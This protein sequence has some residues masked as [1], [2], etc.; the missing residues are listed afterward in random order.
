MVSSILITG[1]GSG[2]GAALAAAMAKRG[3]HVLVS[4]RRKSALEGVAAASDKISTCPG[5]VTDD[6]HQ[7]SLT[8]RLTDLPAPRAVFHG[9]GY[10]QTGPLS[11]LGEKDWHRSFDTNVTARW[12]LTARLKPHLT[13]GR[14]LFIGSDAGA[15][16]RAGAAA[17]SIAQSAS[18][19]LRRA[20]QTEWADEN[21]AVAGFKPGLVDT[22][23][24]RGFLSLSE[25]EFP[26]R[27]DYEAYVASGQI[28]GPDTVAKFAAWLLLDIPAKQFRTTDWDIRD[29]SHHTE[30]HDGP[31]YP[32]APE[33]QDMDDPGLDPGKD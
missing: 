27:A 7:A 29:K 3:C 31:L 28:T 33:Q 32:K 21:I 30:W 17:Y 9:A 20:L 2:I 12:Q 15:N 19:T 26:S 4:G 24:V 8:S 16:P 10:F 25:D 1:G 5:D 23:M 14:I 11:D 6:A 22:N 18:E 13:D